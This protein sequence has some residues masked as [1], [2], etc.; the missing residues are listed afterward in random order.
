M[1][2]LGRKGPKK[3]GLERRNEEKTI[4]LEKKKHMG[5]YPN[6]QSEKPRR[7]NGQKKLSL[8]VLR[9]VPRKEERQDTGTQL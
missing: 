9:K 3:Q 6:R 7:L 5:V 2:E 8:L 1:S 4:L